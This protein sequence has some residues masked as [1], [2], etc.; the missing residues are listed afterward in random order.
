MYHA[1]CR[2]LH[3]LLII[4]A[5]ITVTISRI[6]IVVGNLLRRAI[7]KLFQYESTGKLFQNE[8]RS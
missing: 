7:A 1:W 6:D 5:T 3:E 8:L 4:L 2:Q